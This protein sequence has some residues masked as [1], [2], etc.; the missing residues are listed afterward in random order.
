M[1]LA[2]LKV[3]QPALGRRPEQFA[4]SPD[5]KQLLWPT[6]SNVVTIIDIASR[7]VAG[8]VDVGVEPEGMAVSP[9]GRW[10]VNTLE[11][12]N[13]AHWIDTAPAS[14]WTTPWWTSAA[15]Y[16]RFTD[17]S[18]PL[19][20]ARKSAALSV[21]DVAS[22]NAPTPSACHSGIPK[23]RIQPVG[24]RLTRDGRCAFC[25]AG[26]GQPCGGGGRQN[27]CANQI[28]AGRSPVWHTALTGDEKQPGQQWHQQ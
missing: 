19:W 17:D 6:T 21:I 12:T 9:D 26:P 14:W 20:V 3:T 22:R 10:A 4:L 16:A 23:D 27:L 11:T 25:G 2:T 18:K 1:D 5:G 7:K 15:R 13:M 28:P 8:Q 24:M